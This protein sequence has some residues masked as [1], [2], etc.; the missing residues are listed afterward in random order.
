M[1]TLIEILEKHH[2]VYEELVDKK[3]D[4]FT[5]EGDLFPLKEFK[6][7]LKPEQSILRHL[8]KVLRFIS[9]VTNWDEIPG[10]EN[11][12]VYSIEE[13]RGM[14]ECGG[15]IDYDGDGFYAKDGKESN[16]LVKPSDIAADLYRDKEFDSVVWYNR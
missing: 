11:C 9:P 14:C 8:N 7:Y 1:S 2:E 5:Y 16:I 15:F 3:S 6:E 12:D 10:P 13:F 4:D